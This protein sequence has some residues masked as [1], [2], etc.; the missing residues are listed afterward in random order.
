MT[1][2]EVIKAL[3]CHLKTTTCIGCTYI[4]EQECEVKLCVD[5]VAMLKAKPKR[6][7]WVDAGSLSARCSACG[8]KSS[9][10]TAFCPNCGAEME[11]EDGNDKG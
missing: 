1:R 11:A 9:G 7:R 4:N 5:A 8:C 3:E 2:D 10:E 6:G